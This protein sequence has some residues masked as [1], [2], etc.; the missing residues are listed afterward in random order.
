ME[1]PFIFD[2]NNIGRSTAT[3][4]KKAYIKAYDEW[5]REMILKKQYNIGIKHI[6]TKLH[7][8][9]YWVRTHLCPSL[10]YIKVNPNKLE[11]LGY[12]SHSTLLFREEDL[13]K[14]LVSISVFTRQTIVIDLAKEADIE[15]AL[16]AA[17]LNSDILAYDEKN[18]NV[19]GKRADAL[20]DLLDKD[21]ENVDERKRSKYPE[22]KVEPFDFWS[23]QIHFSSDY[24]NRERAYRDFFLRGFIKIILKDE[25]LKEENSDTKKESKKRGNVSQ[26]KA[27]FVLKED[28]NKIVYPMTVKYSNP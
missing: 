18:K 26:G 14:Y 4:R 16:R 20:L 28:L 19:Y 24:P 25:A 12:D 1:Q 22:I 13:R 2:S 6:M 10:D 7:V 23:Y 11:E 8:S 5:A 9:D 21:Y 15:K 3:A 17:E 27:I